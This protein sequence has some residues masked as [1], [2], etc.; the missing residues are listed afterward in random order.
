MNK[1]RCGL[2][3]QSI[4]ALMSS[5]AVAVVFFFATD[6]TVYSL[7]TSYLEKSN[8]NTEKST[9]YLESF[10][11]YIKENNIAATD[12]K[13]IKSWRDSN[14]KVTTILYIT[15]N[16]ETLYDSLLTSSSESVSL[17]N[18]ESD[19]EDNGE[20]EYSGNGY[21]DNSW[22]FKREI[23]F[24]DG[25]ATVSLYG[26]FDQMIY[27]IAFVIEIILSVIV[28]CTFFIYLLRKK[29][30]YILQLEEQVKVLE[31]GGLDLPITKKGNDE[32]TSLA[33]SLD[34]MRIA[35]SEN[36][37]IE[38]EAVK[39]NYD[40]VVAISHDLRTP[41]TSLALY[42]D[43]I[44][45]GKCKSEDELISYVKKSRGKTTQIKQMTDQLFERFYLEKEETRAIE[46]PDSTKEIFDDL[47][48]N[49]VSYISEN[50]FEVQT[51]I[52][53]PVEKTSVSMDYVARIIDNI[54]SNI[55]KYA[56]PSYPVCLEVGRYKD[57]AEIQ[58]SNHIKMLEMKPDSTKV[59]IKNIRI[60]MDKM[61]G[62]CKIYKNEDEYIIQ[63]FFKLD[64]TKYN[65]S[66]LIAEE[67]K[68]L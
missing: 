54:S 44:L 5:I 21:S 67:V 32:L 63:L 64:Y 52:M 65:I 17:L 40:L 25:A 9:E 34:Q 29:I 19:N 50:G 23:N 42:L 47:L 11:S 51:D 53:W 38:A 12:S 15:R 41:L 35:L 16:D 62:E 24:A 60:M 45:A 30:N 61:G 43:L 14:R 31:T 57:K 37:D 8:Y 4:V 13:A 49:M 39:N 1:R 56:D 68:K 20:Y 59:E 3:T 18:V 26:Y 27:N 22:F 10:E 7:L 48:S 28:L 55:L 2:K 36:M 66:N 33:D 46:K 58:F 6:Y